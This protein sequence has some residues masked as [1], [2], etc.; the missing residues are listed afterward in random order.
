M[1]LSEKQSDLL[2]LGFFS[3]ISVKINQMR[4]QEKAL[5]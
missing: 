3:S 1:G 5:P 2:Q 4:E